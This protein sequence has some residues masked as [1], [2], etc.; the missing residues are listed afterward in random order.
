MFKFLNQLVYQWVDCCT[1]L[2]QAQ[3][4]HVHATDALRHRFYILKR[5][6]L[7]A[8]IRQ[9]KRSVRLQEAYDKARTT[10]LSWKRRN[11]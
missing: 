4:D 5:N 11:A 2:Y 6:G 3:G 9:A 8:A 10:E 1:T 7:R